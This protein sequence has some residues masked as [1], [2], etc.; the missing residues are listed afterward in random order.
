MP[1][2]TRRDIT[3][4]SAEEIRQELAPDGLID[5]DVLETVGGA[6]NADAVQANRQTDEAIGKK[7]AGTTGVPWGQVDACPL[8][9]DITR[10]Y[11][12]A[13]LSIFVQRLSGQPFHY[14]IKGEP[15][16][17]EQLYEMVMAQVHKRCPEAEYKLTFKDKGTHYNR[18]IGRLSL[19][20]TTGEPGPGGGSL[21][22]P[23]YGAPPQATPMGWP[24]S[25]PQ[26]LPPAAAPNDVMMRH[27]F[28]AF[29]QLQQ[30]VV[31][32]AQRSSA[33][34]AA[35]PVAAPAPAPFGLGVGSP[36]L[37]DGATIHV[38]GIGWVTKAKP[39]VE[40]PPPSK[41]ASAV[42]EARGALQTIT[43]MFRMTKEAQGLLPAPGKVAAVPVPEPDVMKTID[44]GDFKI[45]QNTDDGS[46]RPIETA[47][48][49]ADKLVTW[50]AR[51]KE[52]FA[53]ARA[54]Q[55]QAQLPAA[56]PA[57]PQTQAPPVQ[58]PAAAAPPAAPPAPPQAPLRAPTLMS[59]PSLPT[60]R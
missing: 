9:D 16:S 45:V 22:M 4:T 15:R 37:P 28:E 40:Q 59:A 31:Q 6:L 25:Q 10:I 34:V 50:F 35:A 56:P 2:A 49:N 43:E 24:A 18:G 55:Q 38:P 20:D 30:Q 5:P 32:L 8:F 57:A 23:G 1:K 58:T 47:M 60:T 14:Y 33:P 21:P 36:P 44:V 7:R 46:L 53:Q 3:T 26:V 19:P 17:G 42:D 29:T 41:P 52:R 11:A 39:P 48:A 27:L 51:E 12:P 54:A 13:T